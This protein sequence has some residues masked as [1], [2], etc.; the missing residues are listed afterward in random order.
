[1]NQRWLTIL[2][3][4]G[5][6][7]EQS[8]REQVGNIKD[9]VKSQLEERGIRLSAA[10][11]AAMLEEISPKASHAAL[12]YALDM[13]R[14]FTAGMGLRISQ[15]G[16]QHIEVILPART[17]NL[18]DEKQMHDGALVTASTEAVKIL[19]MRHAP[20]GEF[21]INIKKLSFEKIKETSS[22]CRIRVEL[23]ESI[24]ENSLAALRAHR[25]SQLSMNVQIQDE[26]EQTIATLQIE[27]EL[28]HTPSIG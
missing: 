5:I 17:R 26:Q 10:D 4:K 12:G 22:D 15:L 13:T 8:L 20:V 16:D 6:E 18:D 28:Q 9:Q 27:V 24:R 21:R 19:W 14:P 1:M 11:F 2:M 25:M 23:N 3:S 7:F